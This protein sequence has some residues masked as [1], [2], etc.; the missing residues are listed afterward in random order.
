MLK[1]ISPI[2]TPELLKILAEMVLERCADCVQ[3]SVPLARHGCIS[4]T[5][6][7]FRRDFGRTVFEGTVIMLCRNRRG[8]VYIGLVESTEDFLR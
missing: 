4:V 7:E 6:L 8:Y 5:H 1:G 2:L 3:R